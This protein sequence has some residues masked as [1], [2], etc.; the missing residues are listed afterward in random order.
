MST[1]ATVRATLAA[2][3]RAIAKTK[4]GFDLD[5]GNVREYPLFAH[6]D[7]E[8]DSFLMAKVDGQQQVR[9]WALNVTSSDV[10]AVATNIWS[11]TYS[12]EVAG[13]YGKGSNGEG[14]LAA[15]DGATAVRGAIRGLFCNLGGTV[16]LVT[17]ASEPRIDERDGENVGKFWEV[18]MTFTAERAN[19][20]YP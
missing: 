3:I 5:G 13:Y 17:S 10:P 20:A 9:C 14:Y 11:R 12:I 7:S 4:L 16:D 6:H 18:V 15:I 19:P 2:A 8:P 1:E